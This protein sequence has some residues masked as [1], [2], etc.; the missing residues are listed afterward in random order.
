MFN[1]FFISLSV[2]K[3][4]IRLLQFLIMRKIKRG[5]TEDGIITIQ[6]VYAPSS[7]VLGLVQRR[8]N[9]ELKTRF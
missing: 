4:I 3:R 5:K 1:E 8:K 2:N 7:K 6:T 9:N